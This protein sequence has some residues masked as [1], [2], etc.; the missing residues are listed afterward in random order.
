METRRIDRAGME[1]RRRQRRR[2]LM[3]RWL[4]LLGVIVVIVL[5]VLLGMRGCGDDTQG[6]AGNQTTTSGKT[7]TT[8][9]DGTTT[10]SKD[11]SD[12]SDTTGTSTT[13][14]TSS[15]N[16]TVAAAAD[17]TPASF[18][19]T[20]T[21]FRGSSKITDFIRSDKISFGPGKDYTTLPG[22]ITFRGNNYREGASY[23]TADVKLGQLEILW[24]CPPARCRRPAAPA[25]GPAAAGPGQPLIVQWPEDLKQIMNISDAKKADP[26][27]TEIIYPCLDGNIYFLDLKDGSATRP[28]IHSGGGPFKG[29]GSIY[30]DGIPLLFVGH[31]DG[32]VGQGSGEGQALQPDRPE[33]ALHLRHQDR[34][35]RPAQVPRLRLERALRRG[36]RHH[37]RAG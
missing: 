26:D 2:R 8:E 5:A 22:I 33:A 15:V 16:M 18:D 11:G 7:S 19:M 3:L 1:R 28:V 35:Q 36:E 10:T 24:R 21:L 13:E 32:A 12:S 27:L 6:G 4:T 14:A 31:G 30:P 20:T 9:G 37:H 23:G 25:P 34:P 29:T 17:T